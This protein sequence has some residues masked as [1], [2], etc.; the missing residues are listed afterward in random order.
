[1]KGWTLSLVSPVSFGLDA[2]AMSTMVI[3]DNERNVCDISLASSR[4]G[5]G[6]KVGDL[7]AVRASTDDHFTINGDVKFLHQLGKDWA[8]G[9]LR[10]EGDVGI[11][12]GTGMRGGS[13]TVCGDSMM[14]AGCQMKGGAI[15]ITGN[16]GD[17]LGGPLPGRRSGM[18][19]G[20]IVVNG[21][22]GHHAGHCMRR[23]T[24]VI[25][26]DVGDGIG[27]DMVAGTV[28]GGGRVG[29]FVGAGMRRGTIVLTHAISL[30][31][32]RFTSPRE[33]SL[34]MAQLIASDLTLDAPEI[35]I[36]M[37]KP[38]KRCLGDRT[39]GGQGEILIAF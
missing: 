23:G 17:Y 10:I 24:I 32:V 5:S 3:C 29:D 33:V 4:P 6:V 13:I 36:S 38:M 9:A 21:N 28:V 20:R 35:A 22:A 12:L 16:T 18:S 7:F 27:S 1:M 15:R 11:G 30:D 34:S 31:P 25:L 26:G 39:V 2:A 37:T 19:G 8:A 14:S